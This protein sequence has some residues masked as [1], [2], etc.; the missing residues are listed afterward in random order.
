MTVLSEWDSKA[1]LGPTLPRPREALTRSVEEAVALARDID[2]LVV[3]KASGVAH[4][5]ERGLIRTGLD[6]DR[7]RVCWAELAAA[8]DGTVLVAE[9]VVGELELVVGAVRDPQFGPV[10]SV[11]RGGVATEVDPDAVFLLAPIEDG[12][13]EAAVTRLRCAPLLRGFRGR[14]PVDLA[15]LRAVVDAAGALLAADPAVVEVDCNP[16][17]VC[18]GVPIVVDAL[19]VRAQ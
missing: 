6:R 8:G 14:E 3:A 7:L 12:E 1:A 10:V 19:V 16:V 13:L 18:N 4:K 2:G 15:G 5:S 17:V 11:G 9:Q